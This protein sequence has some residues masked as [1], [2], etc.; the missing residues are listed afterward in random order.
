MLKISPKICSVGNK[1]AAPVTEKKKKKKVVAAVVEKSKE[2][3]LKETELP[4]SKTNGLLL[5]LNYDGV[6]K[7]WDDRGTPF[8]DDSPV[9]DAPG[10]DVNVCFLSPTN[11]SKLTP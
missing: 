10:N 9:S 5:K 4:K 11:Q 6:R 8:A 7:A 3:L 2:E 1:A